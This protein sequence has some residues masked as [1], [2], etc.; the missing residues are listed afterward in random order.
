MLVQK[1]LERAYGRVNRAQ[2]RDHLL[3]RCAATG[4][5]YVPTVVTDINAQADATTVEIST[6]KGDQPVRA[7]LATLAGGAVSSKFLEFEAQAPRVAAQTAYGITARVKNYADA[8][9]PSTMVFM[10]YRR[11]HR[12]FVSFLFYKQQMCSW[13]ESL[14]SSRCDCVF[15]HVIPDD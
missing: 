12:Y 4:V 3:S 14:C 1:L 15:F 13:S 8:Y 5:T 9:E 7:R 11:I 2:L 6:A 10:D